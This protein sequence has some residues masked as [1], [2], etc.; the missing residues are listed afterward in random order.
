MIVRW[1]LG[2]LGSALA[3]LGV[4]RPFVF[5]TARH[6]PLPLE[7]V[8]RWS[9][10]PTERIADA[11]AASRAAGADV[12]VAL[13]GGSP[14]DVGKAVSAEADLP[15]LSIP[16]TYSGAEWT[17]FYGIRDA[18]RHMRGGGA[19][20][21]TE[22]IVYEPLLTLG[23]PRQETVGTALNALAHAA[24]ALYV[25][26]RNEAADAHALAGAAL[27][28]RWLPAV[29]DRP[30]ELGARTELLRGAAEC[31]AALGASMLGLGHAMAQALGG[32]YGLPHG[33]LNALCLPPALRFNED[34]APEAVARFG[35]AL[36]ADDPATRVEELAALGEFG[37]LRD[38]GVPEDELPAVAAAVVERAGAKSNPRQASPAEVEE[39]LR[40]IW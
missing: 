30:D 12:L 31:G 2:E 36:G 7:A 39:L 5:A 25:S 20:A 14:I 19:G 34:T 16:T 27:V 3:E 10:L 15:L 22:A 38:L 13:G 4:S 40:S 24:E 23:L 32:T 11:A 37:R 33:A 8:G 21:R 28:G 6:D 29:V 17:A 9:D 35:E 1:G 26:E 18:G